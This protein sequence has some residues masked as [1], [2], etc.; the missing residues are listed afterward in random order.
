MPA[1]VQFH[2]SDSTRPTDAFPVSGPS[3]EVARW[4]ARRGWPVHPLAAGRKVPAANCRGCRTRPHASAGCPCPAAGRWCHGFHSATLDP[5]VIEGWWGGRPEF[6]TGVSCGPAGLVVIDVDAHTT[7]LPERDRLLPGI[8]VGSQVD[9]TGLASGFHSLAVLAA[10]RGER[11]PADDT[12]TL[13]VRTPSGG[14]H[15]WYRSTDRRRWLSS[16][17]SGKGRALAWQVDVR[18]HGS[19]V[20]APGTTTRSG[21]YTLVGPVS[22]PTPLPAW[23][24]GELARTGHLPAP[25][26]PRPRPVPPRARQ[27]VE[28]IGGGPRKAL[29][30][31]L[32]PVDA[33]GRVAEGAGFSE[34]L[35][36][37]A[38]ILG[39][40]VAA[41]RLT[42][43]EAVEA[44]VQAAVSAR[45]GQETR[46]ETIIRSG[47]AAGSK[48]PLHSTGRR[49]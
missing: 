38:Y 6:G 23:L 42:Y 26:A 32:A 24:A 11:S 48:K 46:I 43:D 39:G 16:V 19:Y 14:L 2:H 31:V 20:V 35:N 36:R 49:S 8:P 29:A 37:A 47:L 41:G 45:P 21:A 13:R 22:E 25:A 15:V 4:C 3:F 9:L 44:L 17:G 30:A 34:A 18:A 27:A 1:E 28:A 7:E 12:G 10:L 5:G 33:C 40:L